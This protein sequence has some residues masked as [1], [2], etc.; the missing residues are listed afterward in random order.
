MTNEEAQED[1]L[2]ALRSIYDNIFSATNEG[3]R[4][5]AKPNVPQPFY[6][7]LRGMCFIVVKL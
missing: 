7:I 4:F 6:I 1:E 5:V 3:G 2:I